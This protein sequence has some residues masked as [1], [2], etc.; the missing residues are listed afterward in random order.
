[1]KLLITACLFVLATS[2]TYAHSTTDTKVE[3][4]KKSSTASHH[5]YDKDK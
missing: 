4:S 2:I 5:C 1:M 3:C